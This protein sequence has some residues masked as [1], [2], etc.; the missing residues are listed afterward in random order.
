[1]GRPKKRIDFK[2]VDKLCSLQCTAEEIASF[3]EVSVD[4]L[5]RRIREKFDLTF[6]EY[7]SLKNGAGKISLRRRQWQAAESGNVAMLI[8]LGKQYL[9]QSDKSEHTHDG[10]MGVKLVDDIPGAPDGD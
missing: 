10:S 9:G 7:F 1:M 3:L 5:E 6:A 4:T 2:D 8:W